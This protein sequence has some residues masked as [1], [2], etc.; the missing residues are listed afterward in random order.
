MV[1]LQQTE[2]WLLQFRNL[3]AETS[4]Q[5]LQLKDGG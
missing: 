5:Q 4:S 3:K 2:I 1:K